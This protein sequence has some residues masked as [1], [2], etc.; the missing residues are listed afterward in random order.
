MALK[1][2]EG[3]HDWASQNYGNSSGN[4]AWRDNF[5]DGWAAGDWTGNHNA[6]IAVEKQLSGDKS[7]GGGIVSAAGPVVTLGNGQKV[8]KDQVENAVGKL[9]ANGPKQTTVKTRSPDAVVVKNNVAGS[10]SGKAVAFEK[11]GTLTTSSSSAKRKP[12][13]S[14]VLKP[15]INDEITQLVIAG[16]PVPIDTGWS[17][18]AEAEDRWGEGEF[19]SP[20]W[21]YAWGVVAADAVKGADQAIKGWASS[22]E[23]K[24]WA[25][26]FDNAVVDGVRAAQS[27]L[28]TPVPLPT[29]PILANPQ[30]DAVFDQYNKAA[31]A[32]GPGW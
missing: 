9:L 30:Y 20:S 3:V 7:G 25:T 19:L 5:N 2:G 17:N 12:S 10:P 21:F 6:A 29:N 26:D 13:A 23:T 4:S 18:A 15:T 31:N 8:T 27:W 16:Q 14:V 11:G 22:P 28:N 32:V 1:Q 24:K